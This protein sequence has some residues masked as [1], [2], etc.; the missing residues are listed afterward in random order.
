MGGVAVCA[1][2][3]PRACGGTLGEDF[4]VFFLRGI[5]PA[6]AGNTCR[7][8]SARRSLR[9]HPRACGEH[10]QQPRRS[11]H[12]QGSSPRLRGTLRV[13]VVA[14][15]VHGIIPALAGNTTAG[16]FQ[17]IAGRD[18]PRACGEHLA[19]A[20]NTLFGV[21]SSPRL[22]G[23]RG[24]DLLAAVEEEIIPA[25]AGNTSRPRS[26]RRAAGIIPVLAGNTSKHSSRSS[27][28]WDHPRACGEH[29]LVAFEHDLDRGSS[30]RLRGTPEHGQCGRRA[31]GIIPALA[32][33]TIS[34]KNVSFFLGSSPRL[35]GTPRSPVRAAESDGIIPALA[36]NTC[37][38]LRTSAATWDHPRACGEHSVKRYAEIVE[39][40]SSPRLRGTRGER[41]DGGWFRGIIPA[42][43]GNTSYFFATLLVPWD[44]PRACGEHAFK[45]GKDVLDTGSSPRLRGTPDTQVG[46]FY[47]GGI[48]P[49]L[50]GNT[51]CPHGRA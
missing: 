37:V 45:H 36:G 39:L 15:A 27:R 49:A 17:R 44:H 31:A 23:T 40:G 43:A 19:S 32:G 14:A 18:H 48:I 34:L 11:A 35:R 26:T 25:L 10:Q 3:H 1:W 41:L 50:A 16:I 6:L 29:V 42:L 38:S 20:F 22:R 5:I 4:L 9:D 30:P 51:P 46:E 21:G 13:G 24:V 7:K 28:R 12:R 33:N 8:I 2:D 47:D